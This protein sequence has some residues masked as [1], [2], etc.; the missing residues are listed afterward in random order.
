MRFKL[1]A[2]PELVAPKTTTWDLFRMSSSESTNDVLTLVGIGSLPNSIG[3][4]TKQ[5]LIKGPCDPDAYKSG[6]WQGGSLHVLVEVW[7]CE[8]YPN[9]LLFRR[10]SLTISTLSLAGKILVLTRSFLKHIK[11]AKAIQLTVLYPCD[12]ASPITCTCRYEVWFPSCSRQNI[13]NWAKLYVTNLSVSKPTHPD[14]NVYR[15][16]Q[17][18]FILFKQSIF[19]YIH[20]MMST[21]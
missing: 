16:F 5:P 18:A 11:K 13:H 14:A 10:S 17:C 1:L 7:Q 3:H 2:V 21:R 15:S 4:F 12:R 8:T 20:R 19:T 6:I 9:W